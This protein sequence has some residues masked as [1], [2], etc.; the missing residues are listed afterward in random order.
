VNRI[1]PGA[2]CRHCHKNRVARPRGLCQKCFY[3]P[4]VRDLYPLSGSKFARRGHGCEPTGRLADEPTTH[5]PGTAEKAAVL[6]ARAAAG[7]SL[8]HPHDARG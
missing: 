6:Q 8:F 7:V 1:P 4:G 2:V 3:A 5:K